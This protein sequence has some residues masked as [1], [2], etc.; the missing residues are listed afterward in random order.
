M[1]LIN[2]GQVKNHNWHLKYLEL[3]N[4]EISTHQKLWNKAKA[5]KISKLWYR[6]E[7]F[8]ATCNIMDKNPRDIIL[9]IKSKSLSNAYSIILVPWR[10]N[11][12]K[13]FLFGIQT[14]SV[15]LCARMLSCVQ[16][17]NSMDYST[18]GLLFMEFSRQEY[19]SG[20]QFCSPEDL[21]RPRDWTRVSCIPK[22][23]G[24]FFIATATWEASVKL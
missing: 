14:Y 20:L 1:F 23:A 19:W 8:S 18:P 2:S 24:W 22:L 4:N 12:C 17:C 10:Q 7:W 3:N 6:N 21:P 11:K 15:K 16:I 13:I 9:S 5:E